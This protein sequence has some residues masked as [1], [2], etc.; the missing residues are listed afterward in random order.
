MSIII[1][2]DL[3]TVNSPSIDSQHKRLFAMINDLHDAMIQGKG[4]EIV[5]KTLESLVDYSKVHFADE[6]KM[7]QAIN[8]P[9]LPAHQSEHHIFIQRVYEL[10]KQ[11]REGTIALT[12]PVMEFLRDWLTNHILKVDKKY[13]AYLKH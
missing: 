9:D 10:Q 1:W 8:Y 2:L 11:Y 6:E 13:A 3:Y 12:L 4:S 5:G 7:L